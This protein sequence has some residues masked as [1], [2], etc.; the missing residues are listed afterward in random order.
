MRKLIVALLVKIMLF[1]LFSGSLFANITLPGIFSDGMVLQQQSDVKIWGMGIPGMTVKISSSWDNGKHEAVVT[2]DSTWSIKL[3]TPVA[4]YNSYQIKIESGK[5]SI[6]L[7][8]VLIGEVWL[9]TGQSNMHMPMKGYYN[10]PVLGSLDDIINSSND[11]IR[12]FNI[13]QKNSLHPLKID[14]SG[15]WQTPSPSTT[16]NFSATA[17]YFGRYI[18]RILDIPVG[19]I[20]SSWGGSKIE[21]WMS[22][23]SLAGFPQFKIPTENPEKRVAPLRP[24]V[25]Y[26]SMIYPVAGYG[27]KGAL[28]YQGYSSKFEYKIYPELFKAMH[29]DWN[30]IW[31]YEFPIYLCQNAPHESTNHYGPFMREAQLKIPREQPNTAIAI[32]SDIGEK[33]IVHCADKRTTG[34]RLAY[35]AL[36][37]SYGFEDLPYRSPEFRS[38]NA[39][40]NKVIV[41]FNYAENGINTFGKELNE[42][43]IAGADKVFY[44]A[45]AKIVY[46]TIELSSPDV[47]KP[48][49]VRYGFKNF[50]EPCLF[51]VNGQPV[52]SFRSD[53]WDEVR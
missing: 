37:E 16:A 12:Y 38:L 2:S 46:N 21:A 13:E 10:Q 8:N 24:T 33:E 45:E 17:Y 26:N 43:E 6:T 49:A 14:E 28:W 32:L 19:L 1:P 51:G 11:N 42:F 4:S 48:V 41:R 30:K 34:E 20:H 53:D 15:S 18:Q 7:E 9:C 36:A 25:I 47:G 31:G 50:F 40:D 29:A 5:E 52:S 23:E 35:I 22:K 44:P 27:I 3:N 39:I